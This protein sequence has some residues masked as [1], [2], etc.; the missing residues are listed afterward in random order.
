MLHVLRRL[1]RNIIMVWHTILKMG[2]M[3]ALNDAVI[4]IV[5]GLSPPPVASQLVICCTSKAYALQHQAARILRKASCYASLYGVYFVP[6]QFVC[7]GY[8]C[9]CLLAPDGRLVGAQRAITLNLNHRGSFLRHNRLDLCETSLGKIALLVDVDIN[10]PEITRACALAGAQLVVSNQYIHPA[11]FFEDR[12]LYG[13]VNAATSN[14]I[15]VAAVAGR[16][17][18]IVDH[19]GRR[20]TEISENFPLTATVSPGCRADSNVLKIGKALLGAHRDLFEEPG[21]G[22]YG[23]E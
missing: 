16:T 14:G 21:L 4:S 19:A 11:D 15:P 5:S 2:E 20:L 18:L 10:M 12:L 13:A 22:E 9:L 17:G 1:S 7:G 23:H 3:D 6:Q 8:L